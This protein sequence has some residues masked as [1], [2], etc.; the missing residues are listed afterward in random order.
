[1]DA[2]CLPLSKRGVLGRVVMNYS[3]L[4]NHY[5]DTEKARLTLLAALKSAIREL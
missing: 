1:M 4:I 3:V 5:I 2:P